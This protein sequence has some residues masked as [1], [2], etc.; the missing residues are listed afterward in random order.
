MQR[1]EERAARILDRR[2]TALASRPAPGAAAAAPPR[3]LIIWAVG[4]SLFGL[5]VSAVAAV[6]PFTGCAKVP[7]ADPACLGVVGRAGRFYSVISM[8]RHFDAPPSAAGTGSTEPRHLLL[9]R[10]ASPHLALA[11]DHVLGRFDLPAGGATADLAGRL[12]A[13]VEIADLFARFGHPDRD[14]TA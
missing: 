14:A 6:A 3:S 2:T 10:G 13:V 5:A 7:T 12:V 4:D 8:Q 1:D 9:L 11:V